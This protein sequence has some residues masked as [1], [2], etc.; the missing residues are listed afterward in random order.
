VPFTI[1]VSAKDKIVHIVG[2]GVITVPMCAEAA[3]N[4]IN[5]PDYQPHFGVVIDFRQAT[6]TPLMTEMRELATMFQGYKDS[7]QGR[8]GLVVKDTDAK[9]AS[10]MCMLVRVFGIRMEGYADMNKAFEYVN[11]GVG[12]FN[13]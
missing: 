13:F 7:V 11:T 6:N 4:L 5:N 3:A 9:K 8:I 12:D 2:T 10:V 1:N